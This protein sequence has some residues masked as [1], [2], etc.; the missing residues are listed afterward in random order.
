MTACFEH[1]GCVLEFQSGE[2]QHVQPQPLRLPGAPA[3]DVLVEAR[4]TLML[5]QIEL[6]LRRAGRD[7]GGDGTRAGIVRVC[8]SVTV[9]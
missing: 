1:V 8:V 9:F 6:N 3:I 5:L 2:D 4:L 7:R